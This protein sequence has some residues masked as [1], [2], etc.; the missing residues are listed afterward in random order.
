LIAN[1]SHSVKTAL[2]TGASSG[3]GRELTKLFAKDGYNLVLV[4]RREDR[5]RS[6]ADDMNKNYNTHSTVIPKDLSGEDAPKEIFDF[7]I[8]QG[9]EVDVLVNNAG[10]DVYG[11]FYETNYKKELDMIKVNLIAL[12]YLTKLFLPRMVE[13]GS[14]KILNLGSVGSY[15]AAPLNAIY[16]ATK[17]YVLSMS[18]AVNEELKKTGVSITCLCPGVTKTEFHEVADMEDINEM[19][20]KVMSA[21][22]VAKIG[23]KGLMKGKTI[24]IP[25]F[26][27]KLQIYLTRF[28]SRERVSY[29][30][31]SHMETE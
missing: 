19:K 21:Q 27:N 13:R 18:L 30:S 24:V 3:I 4:A 1:N 29:I 9:I 28:I 25:G 26:K 2:I 10:F 14:G 31:K 22:K 15:V 6:L 23:Y 5:L 17:A 20:G 16:C 7:L 8:Q 11:N 12:T